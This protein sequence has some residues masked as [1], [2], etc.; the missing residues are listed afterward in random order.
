MNRKAT[1]AQVSLIFGFTVLYLLGSAVMA[2]ILGNR[3][4]V[5]YIVVMALIIV[6]LFLVHRRVGFSAKLLAGLSAWGLLHMAGGLVPI[7]TGWHEGLDQ[8]VLYNWWIIPGR[9]KYDQVVHAYGFGL[10]T[11]L[12][13]QALSAAAVPRTTGSPPL[14]PTP[15]LVVLCAAGGMGFGALNEVI[16]FAATQLLPNTNVGGYVN[17]GWDLVFNLLGSALAA[18][19]IWMNGRTTPRKALQES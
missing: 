10:T 4:F 12:C 2:A 8:G 6:S 19:L 13:W 3:E 16:E 17:T 11:W 18:L 14:H 15:G 7:P 1:R 9:L 5:F